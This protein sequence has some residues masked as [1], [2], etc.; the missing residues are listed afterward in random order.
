[1]DW[2]RAADPSL[3]SD[4]PIAARFRSARAWQKG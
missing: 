2:S 4:P 3:P 1:V